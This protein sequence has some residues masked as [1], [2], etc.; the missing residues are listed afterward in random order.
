ML[1]R[2]S[3]EPECGGDCY[4]I[5]PRPKRRGQESGHQ[6]QYFNQ[7]NVTSKTLTERSERHGVQACLL[8]LHGRQAA[9]RGVW[10]IFCRLSASVAL[11]KEA[12]YRVLW[13]LRVSQYRAVKVLV[14][15]QG[16]VKLIE[17]SGEIWVCQAVRTCLGSRNT[18]LTAGR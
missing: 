1:C 5:M 2:N 15:Y 12:G 4:L 6:S 9:G 7:V 13:P 3:E 16:A 10:R 18:F 8:C 17:G 14:N 11:A